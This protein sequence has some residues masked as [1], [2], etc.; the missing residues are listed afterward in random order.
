MSDVY[1]NP[2]AKAAELGLDVK[3]PE[4]N[5]LFIDL[6]SDDAKDEFEH[7]LIV[8]NER[9][10][11]FYGG[12]GTTTTTPSQT[13]GHYHAIVRFSTAVKF[14]AEERIC[15]QALLGSDRVR[16]IL[17]LGQVRS[18]LEHDATVFFEAPCGPVHDTLEE[19]RGEV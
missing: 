5:E 8:F 16:E 1:D 7:N 10:G 17:A 3:R 19:A 4:P 6:D 9:L 2:D 18:G 15:L 12:G 13:E 11:A 14:S